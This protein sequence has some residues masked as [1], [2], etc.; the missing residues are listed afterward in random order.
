MF[1]QLAY[2]AELFPNISV[3]YNNIFKNLTNVINI[4]KLFT[5]FSYSL[6]KNES[7]LQFAANH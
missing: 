6:K 5:N 2:Q 3:K 7:T 4:L 1:I